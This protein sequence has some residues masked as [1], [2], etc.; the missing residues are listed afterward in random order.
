MV[1]TKALFRSTFDSVI[2]SL[3][4]LNVNAFFRVKRGG[5]KWRDGYGKDMRRYIQ[6]MEAMNV[7]K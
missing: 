4:I 7:L 6:V 5:Q 2:F 1:S 3:K